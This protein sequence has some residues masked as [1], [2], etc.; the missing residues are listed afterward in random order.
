MEAN[1][2]EYPLLY[3]RM[4]TV[5]SVRL[6]GNVVMIGDGQVTAGSTIVKGNVRK[7]RRIGDGVIVGFAGTITPS[8]LPFP[9]PQGPRQTRL[10]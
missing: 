3:R 9:D 5:L 8:L 2:S 1:P 10:R 4:T 6:G 7:V